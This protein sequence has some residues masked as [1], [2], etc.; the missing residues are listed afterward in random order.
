MVVGARTGGDAHI[1]LVR[2]PAKWLITQLANY[3]ANCRIPDLNSGFRLIRR[4]L[5][6]RFRSYYPNGFSLTTTIT[7]AALT[8]GYVVK[9]HPI[10]Y[11]HRLGRSKIRPLRDTLN[12]I[13]L[14]IRTVL[15]F[16]PLRI[17][18]P[19][20]LV[21]FA[22]GLAIGIG[23]KLLGDFLDTTTTLLLTASLQ[24]MAIGMLADLVNKRLR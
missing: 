13:Q 15:Y 4:D 6:T 24:I 9:Y 17:F 8:N 2:R 5:W 19:L 23:S 16:D 1:P 22:A 21:L 11:H 14:T 20:S 18:V 7:L 3:L 10:A 12:F